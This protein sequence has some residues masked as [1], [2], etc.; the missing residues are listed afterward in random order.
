MYGAYLWGF[1]SILELITNLY[2]LLF[3]NQMA[4]L[5]V[6]DQYGVTSVVIEM[7]KMKMFL[8]TLIAILINIISLYC[9]FKLIKISK[10]T[11]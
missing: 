2:T 1:I 8:E 3:L 4:N 6:S 7:D 11:V 9:V 5:K 10:P